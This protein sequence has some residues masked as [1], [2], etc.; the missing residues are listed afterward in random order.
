MAT[1]SWVGG[2]GESNSTTSFHLHLAVSKSTS[3]AR[4]KV[5]K[6]SS[7]NSIIAKCTFRRNGLSLSTSNTD[8]KIF[9]GDANNYKTELA[10][11]YDEDN[12]I[13]TSDKT[14]EVTIPSGYYYSG[15]AMAGEL[16]AEVVWHASGT[17]S[18]I[19]TYSNC[20]LVWNFT[21]PT[22][23]VNAPDVTGGTVEG[24]EG[25]YEITT[26]STT[27]KVTLTAKP[28]S[29]YKFVGWSDGVQSATREIT[30]SESTLNAHATTVTYSPVFEKVAVNHTVTFKNADGSTLET[31]TVA[32]G[33]TATAPET[34]SRPYDGD[35]HYTFKGWD[36]ALTDITAD[37]TITAT[38][39]PIPHSFTE[40][41][42]GSNRVYTCSCG[43]YYTE[44]L[45][46]KIYSGTNSNVEIFSGTQR[47]KKVYRGTAKVY[48]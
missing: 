26:P 14:F 4:E 33:G 19:Y 22:I 5:P 12:V 36:K 41:I 48:G 3:N 9:L 24:D 25:T 45:V 7:V 6:Y 28:N 27:H 8:L 18:R 37:T 11:L 29:G 39:N 10:T 17:L 13:G 44:A 34:P 16:S 40:S 31:Q 32:N 38:Y 47:V 30:L 43:Y 21:P 23:K 15:T 2:T 20:T 35:Y 42:E 1:N 46:R